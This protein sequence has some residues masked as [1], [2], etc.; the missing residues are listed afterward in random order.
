[1]K[2]HHR[3]TSFVARA[4]CLCALAT[5]LIAPGCASKPRGVTQRTVILPHPYAAT[6]NA[7]AEEMRALDTNSI[8]NPLAGTVRLHEATLLRN[9]APYYAERPGAGIAEW[10]TARMNAEVTVEPVSETRTAVSVACRFYRMRV[11][12][13]DAWHRWPSSGAFED[14]FIDKVS[15]R[16]RE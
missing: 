11:L 6:W 13:D 1:M 14:E 3:P 12:N 16:L 8:V 10:T 5:L 7:V 15:E 2:T 4:L 9:A